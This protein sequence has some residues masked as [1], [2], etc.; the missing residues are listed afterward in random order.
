MTNTKQKQIIMQAECGRPMRFFSAAAAVVAFGALYWLL[1]SALPL[2]TGR[3]LAVLPGLAV[4]AAYRIFGEKRRGVWVLAAAFLYAALCIAAGF[5][6]F[7]NGMAT[8]YNDVAAQA[9]ASMHFG[10]AS[11]AAQASAASDFLFAS[12]VSV[13]LAVGAVAACKKPSIFVVTALALT[14]LWLCLGLYPSGYALALTALDA[15]ALLVADKGLPL[16]SAVCYLLCAAVVTAAVAPCVLFGGSRGLTDLRTSFS[17]A[18]DRILYGADSLPEGK[19]A[20]A[21]GM[22]S[23]GK[24][25]LRVTLTP[26]TPMLYLKGFVGSELSGAVW[27]PTDKN[28]YVQDGYQGLLDYVG[29]VGSAAQYAQYAALTAD[30]NR[31]AV[32][33]ENVAADRKYLY[34]PYTVGE[35]SVGAPYYDMN[36]RGGVFAARTYTHT[37]FAGDDSC[38]RVTQAPWVLSDVDRTAAMD[39]YLRREGQYRA[40]VYDIYAVVAPDVERVVRD[41]IGDMQTDSIN[42]ATQS[43]RA[44]FLDAFRYADRCDT[45]GDDFISDFFGGKIQTANAAYFASAATCIF[46]VLGFPARYVEGYRVVGGAESDVE[47]AVTVTDDAAHAWTEVY[48]DG[49]GWL[50]IEVTPT[51]FTEKEPDVTVDPETPD[52][53]NTPDTPDTPQAP[54]EENPDTK[55]TVPTVTPSDPQTNERAGLLLALKILLPIAATALGVALVLVFFAVRRTV[56]LGAK[57]KRLQAD[58][59]AFGRAAYEILEQTCR[60]FGGREALSAVGIPV[61]ATARFM[62]IVE[63]SVYGGHDPSAVEKAYAADLIERAATALTQNCGKLRTLYERYVRCLGL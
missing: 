61:E 50:P 23:A 36:V 14:V 11:V 25:R 29:A 54:S 53:P 39:E 46:R 30:D 13:L 19:L 24:T 3:A 58:G 2:R 33:V 9:N 5:G 57:R 10:W 40:F 27:H 28:R 21:D 38:E 8:F 59:A 44:W 47:T 32:T 35:V 37:V 1:V 48:F 49:I 55:P 60:P 51:F 52:N 43:I 15:V 45:V 17:A 12:V 16:R 56:L 18:V 26:H 6:A 4:A 7:R 41:A 22:R 31:Y 42:T 62:Q 34:T 20:A 63:R